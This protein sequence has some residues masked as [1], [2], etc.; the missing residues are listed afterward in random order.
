[1]IQ[2]VL[3]GREEPIGINQIALR[4]GHTHRTFLTHFPLECQLLKQKFQ[5][6]RKQ[7]RKQRESQVCEQVRQ[8]VITLHAEG[9]FPSHHRVRALLSDPNLMRMPEASA[10]WHAIRHDLGIES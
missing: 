3:E 2:A 1:L 9:I 8:A 4:L 6:Y 10:A 7:R 5:E